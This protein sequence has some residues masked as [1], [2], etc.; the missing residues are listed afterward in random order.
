M[1]L[2]TVVD[3]VVQILLWGSVSFATVMGVVYGIDLFKKAK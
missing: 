3:I 2:V 1:E